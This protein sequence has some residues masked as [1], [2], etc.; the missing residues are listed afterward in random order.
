MSRIYCVED[1]E[2]I[3]DLISY[4][5]KS[6]GIDII[7]FENA[8]GF[9]E[10]LKAGLPDMVLLDIMLPDKDGIQLLKELR[11]DEPTKNIPVIIITA[12]DLESDKIKG[13]DLGADDY[14]TKPFSILEL[15]SR[16]KAVLRRSGTYK[17]DDNIIEYNGIKLNNSGRLVSVDGKNIS[18]TYKEFELLYSLL[19][20]RGNAVRRETLLNKIWG[21]EYEGETRT[22]DVHIGSLRHKMGDKGKMIETVR[23]VGYKIN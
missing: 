8:A 9:E 19:K 22:L 18:L 16:I 6:S 10:A 21:Y 11:A 23:N 7:S 15:I 4:A 2:S 13:F 5:V 17:P 14:V 12:K 3:R 20:E 1:D